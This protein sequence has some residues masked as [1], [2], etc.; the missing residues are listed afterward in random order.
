MKF[1]TATQRE[2]SQLTHHLAQVVKGALLKRNVGFTLFLFDFGESG[3]LSYASSANREDMIRTLKEW[4]RQ[5]EAAGE[6]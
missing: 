4:L 1:R 3:F 2:L 6:N 5:A